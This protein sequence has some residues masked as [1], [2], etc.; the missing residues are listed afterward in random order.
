MAQNLD[1]A[2]HILFALCGG[3]TKRLTVMTG[4]KNYLALESGLYFWLP[5]NKK[6]TITLN[7]KDLYDFKFESFNRAKLEFKTLTEINDIYAEDLAGIFE[8]QT[9]L[10]THF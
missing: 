4:A 6:V 3:G 5:R 9:G 2:Q 7:G 8:K 1:L 10:F